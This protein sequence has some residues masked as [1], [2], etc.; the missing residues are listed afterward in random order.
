[1]NFAF[2]APACTER[3]AGDGELAFHGR[4]DS[5]APG[6]ANWLAGDN[7]KIAKKWGAQN[8]TIDS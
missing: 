7:G 2:C 5:L 1:M 6:L 8:I 4:A 3:C